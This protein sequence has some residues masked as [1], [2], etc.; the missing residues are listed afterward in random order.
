[1]SSVNLVSTVMSSVNLGVSEGEYLWVI[2]GL[3]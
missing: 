1:M 2:V 3:V